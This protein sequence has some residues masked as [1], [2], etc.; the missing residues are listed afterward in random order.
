M[1]LQDTFCSSPWFHIRLDPEGNYLPC[2]WSAIGTS[3]HNISNTTMSGYLKTNTMSI[4]RKD[5][6]DGK[7][8]DICHKCQY[9]Q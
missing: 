7:S 9:E 5:M 2:R 6:L 3:G 4:I 1:A 8:P